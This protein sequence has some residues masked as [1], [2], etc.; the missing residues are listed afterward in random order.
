MI[1]PV[2]NVAGREPEAVR[3]GGASS[4]DE[5]VFRTTWAEPLDKP[6]HVDARIRCLRCHS[7]GTVGDRNPVLGSVDAVE[8]EALDALLRHTAAFGL[9]NDRSPVDAPAPKADWEEFLDHVV[10]HR[11]SGLLEAAVRGGDIRVDASK[12][13]EVTA[14]HRQISARVLWL[15]TTLVRIV[16]ASHVIDVPLRVLKGAALARLYPDP[17]WR[18]YL[19]IDLLVPGERFAEAADGLIDLGY[20]RRSVELGPGFDRRFGKGATFRSQTEPTVDLHRTLV[21][22]PYAFLIKPHDLFQHPSLAEVAGSTVPTIGPE[23]TC[24]LACLSATLSD[25]APRL[26]TLRDVVESLRNPALDAERLRQL[27][28]RWHV[29]NTVGTAINAARTALSIDD[30]Q[31]NTSFGL[32]RASVIE[33]FA[34]TAYRG[35]RHRWRR[36]AIGAVPFVPGWFGRLAYIRAIL[37]ARSSD[38]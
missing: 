5:E 3:V 7:V 36:Q 14:L 10:A 25:A 2:E 19:D 26:L 17:L 6:Q 28:E 35:D 13:A 33:R 15:D 18:P 21:A 37:G 24:I 4:R 11:L 1:L 8:T 27:C 29:T 9:A 23:A 12:R 22:G 16:R 31:L 30:H 20:H 32:G 34:T 38:G